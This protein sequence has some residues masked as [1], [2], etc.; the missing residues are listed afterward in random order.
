LPIVECAATSLF[1]VYEVSVPKVEEFEG[2]PIAV[3]A[4]QQWG[5][6]TRG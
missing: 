3:L 1:P 5:V 4:E 2:G 6:S